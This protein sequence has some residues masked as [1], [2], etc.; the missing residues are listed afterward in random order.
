MNPA[1]DGDGPLRAVYDYSGEHAFI[2]QPCLIPLDA[3]RSLLQHDATDDSQAESQE[4]QPGNDPCHDSTGLDGLES[5]ACRGFLDTLPGTF[6]DKQA[7]GCR[8]LPRG[9]RPGWTGIDPFGAWY[10][11]SPMGRSG[12][13]T[14]SLTESR[15]ATHLDDITRQLNASRVK[16]CTGS[17]LYRAVASD[18]ID[19]CTQHS[20]DT[21]L[22]A[23]SSAI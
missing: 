11:P 16:E 9:E 4:P 15:H 20:G 22:G 6:E 14:C 19:G 18:G 13:A 21:L 2:A 12:P 17:L 1:S 7:H 10:F 8:R 3:A 23:N 5:R